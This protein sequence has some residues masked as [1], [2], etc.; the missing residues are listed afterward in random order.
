MRETVKQWKLL[1]FCKGMSPK[2][3]FFNILSYAMYGQKN[4]KL[5][6][7]KESIKCNEILLWQTLLSLVTV[8]RRKRCK[9]LII[10]FFSFT[11]TIVTRSFL[12][13]ALHETNKNAFC[14]RA[15]YDGFLSSIN[16]SPPM[17]CSYK[18][19]LIYT[20]KVHYC[21]SQAVSAASSWSSAPASHITPR[22]VFQSH[23]LN[24]HGSPGMWQ[25][26]S[27]WERAALI[28]RR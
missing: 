8:T 11:L 1:F 14:C 23:P 24:P 12:P 15:G 25:A 2:S 27:S 17:L 3:N 19:H 5:I 13:P 6:E 16:H 20:L 7:H 28:Y 22:S 21:T 4:N 10:T 18:V 26:G 9:P